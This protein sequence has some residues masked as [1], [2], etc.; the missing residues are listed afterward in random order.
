MIPVPRPRRPRNFNRDCLN[1]GNQWLAA[2][3]TAKK[4]RAFWT[5]FQPELE[6]GFSSRCG[7]WAIFITD[8]VVDHYM[9]QKHHPHLTYEWKNYRYSA[10]SVN[11]SKR[12]LDDAVLDPFEVQA[13]WFEVILPSM[14]L[15][16]TNQVPVHMQAKADFTIKKLHL[17][18]GDKIRKLRKRIYEN[19]KTGKCTMAGLQ[20]DAPL[21]AEAV[22]KWQAT[23]RP[24]P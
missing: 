24:L 1:P 11:S 9:S 10:G 15:L 4:F 14:Q 20:N 19:F 7:W 21:I 16:R 23:G 6:K 5:K 3:P 13:G 18:K 2:N 22:I 12:I 17:V 8:G